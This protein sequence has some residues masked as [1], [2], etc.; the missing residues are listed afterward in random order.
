[1]NEKIIELIITELK[2][3]LSVEMTSHEAD[4]TVRECVYWLEVL[5]SKIK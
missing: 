4:E 3:T 2:T 5:K 1:M